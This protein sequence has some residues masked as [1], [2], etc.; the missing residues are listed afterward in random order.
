MPEESGSDQAAA[1]AE[2]APPPK[3]ERWMRFLYWS[4]GILAVLAGCCALWL[5]RIDAEHRKILAEARAAV[6]TLR[7]EPVPDDNNAARDYERAFALFSIKPQDYGIRFSSEISQFRMDIA[8]PE[9]AKLLADDAP[10]L[11]ALAQAATRGRC[12]FVTDY[13]AGM[14]VRIPSLMN[15]RSAGLL[16]AIA[17]RRAARGGKHLEAAE[18]IGQA[19]CLSRG[20]GQPR[21][22][23]THM[24]SVAIEDIAVTALR[25]ILTQTEPDAETLARL[26]DVLREHAEKR[27]RIAESLRG[28]RL[29]I[30][31]TAAE[32][33]AGIKPVNDQLWVRLKFAAQRCSGRVLSDARFAEGLWD[34]TEAAVAKPIHEAYRE[35]KTQIW[36]PQDQRRANELGAPYGWVLPSFLAAV[37]TEAEQ[38]GLLR[39]ARLAVAC[40]LHQARTGKLPEGLAELA[41]QFPKDFAEVSTDPFS[42]GPMLYRRTDTGFVVYSVGAWDP[43][44]NG[45]PLDY[46]NTREPDLTR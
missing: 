39:A 36:T 22:L 15:A 1:G 20:I 31:L 24:I 45:A 41:G 6:E 8:G 17:A 21:T 40:R 12:V 32:V 18:R 46:A 2:P 43:L 5:R 42:G 9:V 37:R 25:D 38:Q 35:I 10:A 3:G 26:A 14:A 33:A 19:L 30:M 4:I 16:L 44:D 34:R 27:P 13:S 29:T 28:E 7:V 23:I 11:A